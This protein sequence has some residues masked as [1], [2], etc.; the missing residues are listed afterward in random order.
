VRDFTGDKSR[1]GSLTIQPG[2]ALD[3]RHR[4]VIH[5]GDAQAAGIAALALGRRRTSR[6]GTAR[7]SDRRHKPILRGARFYHPPS[8]V[9]GIGLRP[10]IHESER[11]QERDISSQRAAVPPESDGKLGNRGWSCANGAEQPYPLGGNDPN[12]V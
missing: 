3:F 4:V 12:Q 1:H 7:A 5:P 2:Q 11:F 8:A 6:A 9:A 10:S